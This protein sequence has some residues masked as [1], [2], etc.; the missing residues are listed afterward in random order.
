ML[1]GRAKRS[2][3]EGSRWGRGGVLGGVRAA[4]SAGVIALAAGSAS[5]TWSIIIIDTRTGEIAVGSA[6]CLTGFDLRNNTPV[7][8]PEVGAATAQSFVDSTGQNRV[9][10]RDLLVAGVHPNDILT[11]LAGF[12]SGHQTRQYGIA[13]TM[14][15]TATFSGT[16]AGAWAG[17]EVG[18]IGDLVYA[19][20]GNVL[21]GEPVVT[22]AV[23]AILDTPGDLAAKLMASME[24]ARAFGGDGRCSCP[25]GSPTACGAPPPSF[26]K[27]A[28]IAYML[29]ARAGDTA[30][31]NGIYTTG[32]RPFDIAIGDV[33][34]DGRPDIVSGAQA[35][36]SVML[37]QHEPGD[38]FVTFRP[39]VFYTAGTDTRG[40]ALADLN[41]DGALDL[42]SAA[43]GVDSLGVQYGNGDGTF[44]AISLLPSGDGA[45]LI[46]SG[47]FN[48]DGWVDV[49]ITNQ[50]GNTVSVFLNDGAG[51]LLPATH[52]STA[53]APSIIKVGDIDGDGDLDLVML[54]NGARVVQTFVNNGSGGFAIG[55]ITAIGMN[56]SD[57]ALVDL[58]GDGDLDAA[59]TDRGSNVVSILSN[60][61]SG[62]FL[63]TTIAVAGAPSRIGAADVTGDGLLDLLI[64]TVSPQ[65]RTNVYRGDGT[66]TFVPDTS[67]LNSPSGLLDIE[68]VDL[69]GDG[70]PDL[71]AASNSGEAAIIIENRG[72][73]TFND[74]VGCATGAYYMNFNVANTTASAPE[75]VFTL[76]ASYDQWR[77]GLTGETDAIR[78]E[79]SFS[80]GAL[81][82][83]GV[84][85]MRI[86][87]RDIEGDGIA[88]AP[89]D[90]VVEHARGSASLAS[91][92]SVEEVGLGLYDVVLEGPESGLGQDRFQ[93]TA[94]GE[95]RPVV[96]MPRPTLDVVVSPADFDGD[97][98]V[99]V[100]DLLDF[101]DA[102]SAGLASADLDGNGVVDG[103]DVA[104]FLAAFGN[105]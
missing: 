18:Q 59:T 31:C 43:Y 28:H 10:V 87:L 57:M 11:A 21:T 69:N 102:F 86:R 60:D 66:G 46:A 19:V 83:E 30:G 2:G 93:I 41:N 55:T 25:G 74:G 14:G 39:T 13:D 99:G 40:V 9:L 45:R 36:T 92:V 23:Q 94:Y 56:P 52:S 22:N 105:G 101:F 1:Q 49:A 27:S 16:G 5:A 76:R 65:D 100:L 67:F 79:V 80:A 48:D 33:D 85:T 97:G 37:N 20:Q 77:S 78:S 44:G 68:I 50:L 71:A 98:S 29:I 88:R 84:V 72:D 54:C 73:G 3:R 70:A 64:T 95:G 17:G 34:G 7:L 90:L 75:P 62:S 96:L 47:D 89:S 42:L 63:R 104:L 81:P 24:A 35:R 53:G 32:A 38:L 91:I 12:D 61:G 103:E 82:Q 8:I 26:N 6:T 51:A 58:D 4:T 15:G